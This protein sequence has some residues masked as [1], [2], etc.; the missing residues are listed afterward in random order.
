MVKL[1]LDKVM[2]QARSPNTSQSSSKGYSCAKRSAE[3]SQNRTANQVEAEDAYVLNLRGK[4]QE[5]IVETQTRPV[6]IPSSY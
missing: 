3:V 4:S 1:N 5:E 6:Q 2:P